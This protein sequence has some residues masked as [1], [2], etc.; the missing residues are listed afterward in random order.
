M[1]L[2]CLSWMRDVLINNHTSVS[3]DWIH[4]ILFSLQSHFS[5]TIFCTKILLFE[6]VDHHFLICFFFFCKCIF[7]VHQLNGSNASQWDHCLS[8]C[9]QN[10]LLGRVKVFYNLLLSNASALN[11][12]LIIQTN[13]KSLRCSI[14]IYDKKKFTSIHFSMADFFILFHQFQFHYRTSWKLIFFR[15]QKVYR[16]MYN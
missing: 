15:F 6:K 5:L 13:L 14:L 16:W 4:Q 12:Q 7:R 8:L 1:L 9:F 3:F 2:V 11:F 10:S